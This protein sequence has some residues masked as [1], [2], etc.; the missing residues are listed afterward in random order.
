MD[1][2]AKVS[3]EVLSKGQPSRTRLRIKLGHGK[4]FEVTLS[5]ISSLYQKAVRRGDAFWTVVSVTIY[6]RAG[7]AFAAFNNLRGFAL[8]DKSGSSAELLEKIENY[9]DQFKKAYSEKTGISKSNLRAGAVEELFPE[10]LRFAVEAALY[11]CWCRSS[12]IGAMLAFTGLSA[13]VSENM[14]SDSTPNLLSEREGKMTAT[15]K[16]ATE[17]VALAWRG[18]ET[19]NKDVRPSKLTGAQHEKLMLELLREMYAR[20]YPGKPLPPKY[21]RYAVHRLGF[22]TMAAEL[23]LGLKSGVDKNYVDHPEFMAANDLPEWA[24]DKHTTEG[25]QRLADSTRGTSEDMHTL[26]LKKMFSDSFNLNGHEANQKENRFWDTVGRETY[27]WWDAYHLRLLGGKNR[28]YSLGK[29]KHLLDYWVELAK[30]T[31]PV[32]KKGKKRTA[33]SSSRASSSLLSSKPAATEKSK[34]QK[35]TP[36]ERYEPQQIFRPLNESKKIGFPLSILQTM[37]CAA[38][39]PTRTGK[40]MLTYYT[41]NENGQRVWRKGPFEVKLRHEIWA[42]IDADIVFDVLDG[43]EARDLKEITI[44]G[45]M[46]VESAALFWPPSFEERESTV[47]NIKSLRV[48]VMP[49]NAPVRSLSRSD[50]KRLAADKEFEL[51]QK[52]V[53]ASILKRELGCNDL[54]L[55]NLIVDFNKKLVYPIDCTVLEGE[56]KPSIF[57]G[58]A[59]DVRD[60]LTDRRVKLQPELYKTWARDLAPTYPIAAANLMRFVSLEAEMGSDLFPPKKT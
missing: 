20:L 8:E 4:A 56:R 43:V 32:L 11:V 18:Y 3:V 39:L 41:L 12:R 26:G 29:T 60:I 7:N 19:K 30:E 6:Y 42:E 22:A 48:G 44:D 5:A 16:R 1:W 10:G 58:A 54:V 27:M 21:T 47:L 33:A 2:T 45:R 28:R 14:P 53:N 55:R 31:T 57:H 15:R 13:A 24:L 51:L 9:T 17:E 35:P 25:R 50:I 59:E 40:Q 49:P 34:K 36:A 37:Y 38:Q 52:I 46:F 23:V